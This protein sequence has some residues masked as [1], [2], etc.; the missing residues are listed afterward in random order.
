[1]IKKKEGGDQSGS[2]FKHLCKW[3]WKNTIL[4]EETKSKALRS[5]FYHSHF[6]HHRPLS[7]EIDSDK[8]LEMISAGLD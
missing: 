5:R 7:T 6:H 3:M 1:M 4:A 2:D 8:H